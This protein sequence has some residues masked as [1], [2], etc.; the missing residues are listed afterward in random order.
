MMNAFQG[1]N[2]AINTDT[3][4]HSIGWVDFDKIII[5]NK[6]EYLPLESIH[7]YVKVAKIGEKFFEVTIGLR[8]GHDLSAGLAKTRFFL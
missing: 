7:F 1:N 3:G 8:T 2:L 5:L 4:N 6:K